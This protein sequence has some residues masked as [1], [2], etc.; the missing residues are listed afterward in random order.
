MRRAARDR[1]VD[2]VHEDRRG[3]IAAREVTL[4]HVDVEGELVALELGRLLSTT[5]ASTTAALAFIRTDTVALGGV[6]PKLSLPLHS[7]SR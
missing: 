1:Q 6:L 5:T 3:T 2:D 4:Q 7:S